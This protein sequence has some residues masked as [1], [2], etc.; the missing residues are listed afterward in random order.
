MEE[1]SVR[2]V[3]ERLENQASNHWHEFSVIVASANILLAIVLLG[4]VVMGKQSTSVEY[5]SFGVAAASI[6]GAVL[7]YYSIQ[8]GTLLLFGPLRL[9][10]VL[11][12]FSIAGAQLA[13]FLWPTY[14]LSREAAT[15]VA[16]VRD[17][18]HWLLFYSAFSFAAVIANWH[19][20]VVRKREIRGSAFKNYEAAQKIDLLA[21]GVIGIVIIFCWALSYIWLLPSIVIGILVSIMSSVL[22]MA[23]QAQT[24]ARLRRD[25]GR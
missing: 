5:I 24:S 4:R 25:L 1:D 18:R 2:R 19:A 22:G 7:A 3:R 23:T 16:V 20:S 21:A 15:S 14:V 8:V 10:Q 17:L 6:L 12:S 13:L 9:T 11:A